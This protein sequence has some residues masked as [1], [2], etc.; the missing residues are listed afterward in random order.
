MKGHAGCDRPRGQVADLIGH[1]ARRQS[2]LLH[3]NHSTGVGPREPEITLLP[4]RPLVLAALLLPTLVACAPIIRPAPFKG[5]RTQVTDTSL[6]GP[7]DGQIVDRATGEPVEDAVV[8]GVWSYNR[9]DGFIGPYGS[10]TITVQ[11]DEAGRYRIGRAPLNKRGS[12]L[13]LVSFHLIVYKRGYGGYRSDTLLEGDARRDFTGRHNRI[14]LEKW[15]DSDSRA[16]HLLFLAPPREIARVADWERR[17]AN[18]DFYVA[19]GGEVLGGEQGEVAGPGAELPEPG[20]QAV[21]LDA[22]QLIYPEDIAMRTG[23]AGEFALEDLGDFP[24]TSFYHGLLY[25]AVGFEEEFDFSLRVWHQPSGG[26]DPV[27]EIFNDALPVPITGEVTEETWV[28]EEP[29][30]LFRGVAFVDRETESGVLVSCGP[31]QCID[32]ATAIILAKFIHGRLDQLTTIEAGPEPEPEPEPEPQD[33]RRIEGIGPKIDAALKAA[34]YTTYAKVAG[35]S[36]TELREALAAGGIKFAPA[37]ASWA[38]QAQYLADGDEDGLQ[39]YQDYLVGG[40]DRAAKF[41]KDVDYTDVDEVDGAAAKAAALS[42]DEAKTAADG[43]TEAV[44][45]EAKA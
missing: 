35:A 42:E 28:Y 43:D 3:V 37:A 7:F 12:S 14:E 17:E 36:E 24:R 29:G 11:T 32:M 41:R 2:K 23:Y 10:E 44:G 26:L 25:R 20:E 9:G 45:S 40:Q 30:T 27:T 5:S 15:R 18:L 8:V 39:E 13:R 4:R 33:L 22:S 16:Q 31:A 19:L 1:P 38:D 21:W 34:G 6:I